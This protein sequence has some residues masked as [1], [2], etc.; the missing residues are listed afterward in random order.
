MASAKPRYGTIN[1]EMVSTWFGRPPEQD[2]PFWAVNLMKYRSVADYG[3]GGGPAVSGREADD[4]YTPRASLAAIGAVIA[5]AADVD[6]TLAG[7]PAWDRVGIVRYPSRAGFL[8]MQQR[9]D[10]QARH[11][12]KDAGME[13]TI[14]MSCFPRDAVEPIASDAPGTTV[15]RVVRGDL[16]PVEGVERLATFG[17]EGVIVGDERRWDHV[18]FE[19]A[20]DDAALAA[21][22]EVADADAVLAVSVTPFLDELAATVTESRAA[23][24]IA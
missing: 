8:E 11:V 6:R 13:L 10:F 15:L 14:V 2:P 24:V 4:R 9:E 17:V 18:V 7:T 1:V 16:A 20:R 12:H 23:G 19:R 22:T 5:F 21:L 3:A